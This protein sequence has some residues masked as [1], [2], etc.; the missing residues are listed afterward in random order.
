MNKM[1]NKTYS[2]VYWKYFGDGGWYISA[3][4]SDSSY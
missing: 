4:N 2:Y 3:D 1:M